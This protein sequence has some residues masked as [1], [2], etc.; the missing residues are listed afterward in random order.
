MKQQWGWGDTR[1][2]E[3]GGLS[4]QGANAQGRELGITQPRQISELSNNAFPHQCLSVVFINLS[5]SRLLH[6]LVFRLFLWKY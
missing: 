1:G 4:G 3:E 2:L 5:S 6:M